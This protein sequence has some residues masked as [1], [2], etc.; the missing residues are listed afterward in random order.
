MNTVYHK[1]SSLLST[2]R[3]TRATNLVLT[4]LDCHQYPSGGFEDT[5]FREGHPDTRHACRES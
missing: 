5:V 3:Y 1:F 2:Q 4:V